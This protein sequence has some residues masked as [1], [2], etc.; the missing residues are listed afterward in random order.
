VSTGRH[1]ICSGEVS[2]WQ[3]DRVPMAS[4]HRGGNSVFFRVLRLTVV[5][6]AFGLLASGCVRV[7]AALAVSTDDLVSGDLVIASLPSAQ[8]GKGPT[9]TIP[10][11]LADRVSTK[12]YAANGY[13][14]SDLS[15]HDLTFDDMSVLSTA[16]SNE[17][18]DYKIAFARNGDLV[19]LDGSVDLTQLPPANVDV[20]LKIS[21]PNPPTRADGTVSGNTVSW[22][23]K[24]GEV[25][26][27]SAADQ[28]SLGNTRGWR[29]WAAALG[30][31][32]G[33]VAVFVVLLAL[34]ARRRNLKK[35][36]AYIAATT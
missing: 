12:S 15:F 34:L 33:I 1:G 14:G 20:Q 32:G 19:T 11:N 3:D 35:E 13:V 22:T 23:I 10:S 16:I 7:H 8:N 36:R 24:A 21:F 29:F 27:F 28:Y 9:L 26:S 25:T 17:T 6:L 2:D 18:G 5:L 30:G 31:G 4:P